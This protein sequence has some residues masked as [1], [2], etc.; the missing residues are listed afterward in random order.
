MKKKKILKTVLVILISVIIICGTCTFLHWNHFSNKNILFQKYRADNKD[1]YVLGT[2]GKNHFK[3]AYNYSMKNMLSVIENVKPDL[4]LLQGREDHYIDYGIVDGNIDASVA[5]SYCF[6]NKIPFCFI[7]WW[8]IDNI[9]PEEATTNL[10]D[11]N[12]FIRVSRQIKDAK[13]GSKILLLIDSQQ[14]YE[15]TSRFKVAGYKQLEIENKPSYFEGKEG[16]FQFPAVVAKTWRD[17]NYFF[18][19]NFPTEVS[20]LKD[21]DEDIKNKFKYADHDKFY[22]REIEYCKYLNND[23]LF[24]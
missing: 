14:F 16:K 22:L 7:D 15:I 13:P 4:C 1:V 12:I 18:A 2:I 11:D 24:K 21:L 10:R 23:I 6:E 9:Y 20:N 17:R 8:I 5:Y 19:Y 3:K